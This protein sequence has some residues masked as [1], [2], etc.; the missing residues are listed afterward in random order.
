MQKVLL[1]CY[2]VWVDSV[3]ELDEE[4]EFTL[5]KSVAKTLS[6]TCV[7]CTADEFIFLRKFLGLSKETLSMLFGV[8]VGFVGQYE[9]RDLREVKFKEIMSSFLKYVARNA[10][11]VPIDSGANCVGVYV[12]RGLV[13]IRGA[14]IEN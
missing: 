3:A 8:D 2:T 14:C 9:T 7:L 5:K 6:Q 12:K 1:G 13:G 11:S 10:L 4:S